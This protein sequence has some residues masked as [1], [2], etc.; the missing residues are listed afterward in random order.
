MISNYPTNNTIESPIFI[1]VSPNR[2]FKLP[3]SGK[4]VFL[5]E[6]LNRISLDSVSV[7]FIVISREER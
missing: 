3:L 7:D 5:D 4:I 1:F 2:I 6:R